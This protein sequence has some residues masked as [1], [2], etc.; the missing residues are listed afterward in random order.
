MYGFKSFKELSLATLVLTDSF[1]ASAETPARR[2][3]PPE[4]LHLQEAI[5]AYLEPKIGCQTRAEWLLALAEAHSRRLLLQAIRFQRRLASI[6]EHDLESLTRVVAWMRSD[7]DDMYDEVGGLSP[8][9]MFFP[10]ARRA[11]RGQDDRGVY[12]LVEP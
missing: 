11:Q 4:I 8:R 12:I 3:L 9:S 5:L 2:F 6:P 1:A 7:I 10:A